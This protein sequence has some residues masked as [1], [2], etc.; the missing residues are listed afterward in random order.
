MT[1]DDCQS[2]TATRAGELAEHGV[3]LTPE[4]RDEL[5]VFIEELNGDIQVAELL[6][7][8]AIAEALK[9]SRRLARR[10]LR[11]C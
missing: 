5:C 2:L 10:D 3:A 6:G 7:H 1:G 8:I 11:Q 4:D 9:E